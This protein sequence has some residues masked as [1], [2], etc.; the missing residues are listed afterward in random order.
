MPF[1]G[2]GFLKLT[3]LGEGSSIRIRGSN[4]VHA[5]NAPLYVID[6]FI[7]F[8]D[9]QSASVGLGGIESNINPLSAINPAD[10]ESVCLPPCVPW[11]TVTVTTGRRLCFKQASAKTT[12]YRSVARDCII[13]IL[14]KLHIAV[15]V[16][17]IL[18]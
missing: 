11:V 6:G 7:F 10:I 2:M 4:S 8:N 15:A 13:R 12:I 16:K 14:V 18:K 3:T 1:Q 17:K 9:K 5:D